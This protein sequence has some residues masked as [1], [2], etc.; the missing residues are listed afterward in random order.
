METCPWSGEANTKEDLF[1]KAAAHAK[2][3]HGYTKEQLNDPKTMEL[4]QTHIKED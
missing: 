2:E 3:V 4:M 1:A